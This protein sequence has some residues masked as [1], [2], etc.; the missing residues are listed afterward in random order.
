MRPIKAIAS[1]GPGGLSDSFMRGLADQLGPAL[2][3]SIVV[4]DRAGAEGTI[5][6][7]AGRG[8]AG[9]LH[10]MHPARRDGHHQPDHP[11]ESDSTRP[12]AWSRSPEPIT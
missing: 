1:Q 12:K 4:E 6:A 5:G 2:G 8:G 9:W 10:Y 3:T 11:A 7:Q